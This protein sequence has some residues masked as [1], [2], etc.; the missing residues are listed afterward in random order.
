MNLLNAAYDGDVKSV[1]YALDTGVPVDI[2][3]PVRGL[4]AEPK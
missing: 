3:I 2:V 4:R 1:D